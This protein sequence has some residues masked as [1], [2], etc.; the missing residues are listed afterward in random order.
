MQFDVNYTYS[1]SIDV[2]SNAER[3]NG[4]ESGGI[5]FNS[6]VIN[7]FS[8]NLW[9][10]ASDFDTTHQ[11]NANL[12]L[13]RPLRSRPALRAEAPMRFVN[14]VLG[15]WTVSGLY[16]WTSGFPFS[17]LAGN[18]WATDF[19]LEGTS[20]VNG[21]KPKDWRIPR[22]QGDPNVFQNAQSL[23]CTCFRR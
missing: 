22:C 9:R 1:K 14:A 19:E 3:V 2:G 7:A 18:G 5:A 13:G 8:P 17:V 21:A 10:A 16:R 20:F 6:Q 11:I 15:G 12:D 23:T 4:F